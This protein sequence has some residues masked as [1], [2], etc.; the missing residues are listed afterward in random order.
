MVKV[1]DVVETAMWLCGRETPEQRQAF[2]DDVRAA[3]LRA[4]DE[5]GVVLGAVVYVEKRPGDDRVPPVPDHIAGPDVRLLVAEAKAICAMPHFDL[6]ESRFVDELEPD[7]LA[8]L[9]K[10]TRDGYARM[11]AQHGFTMPPLTDRQCDTIISD[12]GPEAALDALRA[13][14]VDVLKVLH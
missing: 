13:D 9:R 2:E 10:I 1:G 4:Q 12:L 5:H 8:R 3:M 11:M 6:A 14:D 7:D